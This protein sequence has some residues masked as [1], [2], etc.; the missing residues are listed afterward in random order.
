MQVLTRRTLMSVLW[1]RVYEAWRKTTSIDTTIEYALI[2]FFRGY[3]VA[4]IFYSLLS[5]RTRFGSA[6]AYSGGYGSQSLTDLTS[7]NSH[8]FVTD[9]LPGFSPARRFRR[10]ELRTF[11]EYRISTSVSQYCLC[12]STALH[13][14]DMRRKYLFRLKAYKQECPVYCFLHFLLNIIFTILLLYWNYPNRLLPIG[15]HTG[16]ARWAMPPPP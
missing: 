10:P 2:F 1:T 8:M 13:R 11:D 9:R 15:V 4:V 16:V 3:I 12:P 7:R 6:G 14:P 5:Q